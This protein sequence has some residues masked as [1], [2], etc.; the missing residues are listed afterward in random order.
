MNKD[1]DRLFAVQTKNIWIQGEISAQYNPYEATPYSILYI[2][3]K[4][5]R[6]EKTDGFVDFGCGKG[7]LL[8]YVHNLFHCA[9]TGI[10]MDQYLY[11]RAI[12]NKNKYLQ[13]GKRAKAPIHLVKGFAEEYSIKDTENKFY[14]FNPFSV[15]I[16]KKVLQNILKSVEKNERT[17]DLIF[18]YPQKKYIEYLAQHTPFQLVQ[19]IRIPSLSHIN[20]EE[21]FLIYRLRAT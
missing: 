5:Y 11:E 2:L 7:R 18:Y 19:E 17:V 12:Q 8:F 15:R 3:F 4:N 6:L 9:V 10:E 21:R 13:K 1:Y 14:F 16:L 20:D